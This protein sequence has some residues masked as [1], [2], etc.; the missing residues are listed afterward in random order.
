LQGLRVESPASGEKKRFCILTFAILQRCK[1]EEQGEDQEGAK[2]QR[3]KKKT[4]E[5]QFYRLKR[6]FLHLQV[7]RKRYLLSLRE[8]L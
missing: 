5:V 2:G 6:C 1:C 3:E 7:L 8:Q 4:V